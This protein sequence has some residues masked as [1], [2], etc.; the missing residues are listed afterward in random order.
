MEN[1]LWRKLVHRRLLFTIRSSRCIDG[2]KPTPGKAP[3]FIPDQPRCPLT[4]D[5]ADR[6][7][8]SSRDTRFGDDLINHIYHCTASDVAVTYP[9]LTKEQ[10]NELYERHYSNSDAKIILAPDDSVSPY[11]GFQGG[12]PFQRM[13]RRAV[14]PSVF[15]HGIKWE[16][17][18]EQLISNVPGLAREGGQVHFLDVGCFD[19]KLLSAVAR[20][21]DWKTY[22]LEQ[23]S[24]PAELSR[25]EGHPVWQGFAEDAT[26]VIPLEMSFDVIHLG[27]TIEHLG[28]PLTVVRRLRGL[29]KPGGRIVLSTPN[30][31]SW[32]LYLFAPTW[33]QWQPPYHRFLFSPKSLKTMA[34]LADMDLIR[35]RSYSHPYWTCMSV[36][37]NRLGCG[38]AVPHTISFPDDS[39]N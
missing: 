38:A 37:L 14:L 8:F 1:L 31:H 18:T 36:Q 5:R 35:L 23:N 10:L 9:P 24:K 28:D 17:D 25:R 15:A 12:N 3:P 29:L 13:L 32:Q 33:S 11:V 27:Q 19:G 39:V 22:S 6:L 21:T 7:L 16:D 34:K 30:L 2:A 20:C 26:W 4:D